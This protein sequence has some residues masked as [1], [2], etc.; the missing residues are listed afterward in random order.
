MPKERGKKR[1]E[2]YDNSRFISGN[3]AFRYESP[4]LQ[5]NLILEREFHNPRGR[6]E[7]IINNRKWHHFFLTPSPIIIPLIRE[8]YANLPEHSNEAVFVRGKWVNFDKTTINQL[9]LLEDID[10]DEYF[11]FINQSIDYDHI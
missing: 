5:K 8:F 4:I 7:N 3:A 9:Y 6:V 11:V 1:K 10:I 2:D